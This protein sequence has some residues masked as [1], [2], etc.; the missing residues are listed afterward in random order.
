MRAH[1]LSEPT[2]IQASAGDYTKF[3][4]DEF[5]FA[6]LMLFARQWALQ[7]R[8][9]RTAQVLAE[10]DLPASAPLLAASGWSRTVTLG[11]PGRVVVD[12]LLWH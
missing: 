5:A 1:W 12:D 11:V 3:T 10:G 8:H 2:L 4:A 9:E 6:L 7:R